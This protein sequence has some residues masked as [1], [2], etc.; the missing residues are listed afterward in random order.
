MFD[1]GSIQNRN[2]SLMFSCSIIAVLSLG[3]TFF[4]KQVEH[5]APFQQKYCGGG[6]G[7][8]GDA[9]EMLCPTPQI[10]V[11]RFLHYYSTFFFTLYYFLFNSRYD[12]Y[13][14]FLYALLIFHWLL[15]NDCVLSNWE[16][17]YYSENQ[18]ETA[19]SSLG[20]SP[21]LHPHI[22]VFVGNYTDIVILIQGIV[23][24]IGFIFVI[25]RFQFKYYNY[26]FAATILA[27]QTY[28]MLKDRI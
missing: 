21:L 25:S 22:R 13:Y 2:V 23:M 10:L 4:S 8:E 20:E 11:V 24:T 5:A 16:M 1:I 18:D 6:G 3:F 27:L 15:T 14:L 26:L 12:F 17:S 28:L 9:T 7:A 19:T